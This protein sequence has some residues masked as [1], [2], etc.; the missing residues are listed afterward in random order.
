MSVFCNALGAERLPCIACLF[1]LSQIDAAAEAPAT[2]QEDAPAGFP[3]QPPNLRRSKWQPELRP[4][5]SILKRMSDP[6]L[7]VQLQ[8]SASSSKLVPTLSGAFDTDMLDVDVCPAALNARDSLTLAASSF[9]VLGAIDMLPSMEQAA[10][11]EELMQAQQLQEQQLRS[12]EEQGSESPRS[13]SDM[14]SDTQVDMVAEASKQQHKVIFARTI[15][16]RYIPNVVQQRRRRLA[17]QR[18]AAAAAAAAEAAVAAV[19]HCQDAVS[20]PLA[21]NE[22]HADEASDDDDDE[23]GCSYS[24][25]MACRQASYSQGLVAPM[26][27][28]ASEAGADAA[29]MPADHMMGW[30]SMVASH[31]QQEPAEQ[32][33]VCASGVP[34]SALHHHDDQGASHHAAHHHC[35]YGCTFDGPSVFPPKLRVKIPRRYAEAWARQ[36]QQHAG[37]D[38]PAAAAKHAEQLH[39]DDVAQAAA[40]SAA[41]AASTTST[42]AA[43]LLVTISVE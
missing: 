4:S 34:P 31:G 24:W 38:S 5:K 41:A 22:H 17:A 12:E 9:S 15:K 32:Q 21:C 23:E 37:C 2:A 42:P 19:Q 43:T 16:V 36:Q 20:D 11:A 14:S 1:P 28:V 30:S 25:P 29:H 40:T 39:G 35:G 27:G 33:V 6:A 18:A 13:P 7:P 3:Q 8:S 26:H 10:G